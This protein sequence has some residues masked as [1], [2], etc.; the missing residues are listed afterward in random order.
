MNKNIVN[1]ESALVDNEIKV[2]V[3]L[4]VYRVERY[5]ERCI[6]SLLNQT[7]KEIEFIFVD[8]C[9]GDNSIKFVEK[10][11]DTDNRIKILYNETNLGTGRS[12]NKGIEAA[13]GKYIGFVD[14]DD[15]IDLNYYEVLYNTAEKYGCDSVKADRI[16]VFAN[17]ERVKDTI[18]K[19][20][21]DFPEY[22][23]RDDW[24]ILFNGEHQTGIYK[25]EIIKQ[26]NIRNG[27]SKVSQDTT[28]LLRMMSHVKKL[29]FCHNV[30][31][32]YY[33]IEGS[34]SNTKSDAYYEAYIIQLGEKIISINEL[35]DQNVAGQCKYVFKILRYAIFDVYKN[36][37]N[38]HIDK[39]D[40]QIQYLKGLWNETL[41]FDHIQALKVYDEIDNKVK[42]AWVRNLSDFL[43]GNFDELIGERGEYNLGFITNNNQ[44]QKGDEPKLETNKPEIS[45]KGTIPVVFLT[46]DNYAMTTAVA[47]TSLYHNKSRESGYAVYIIC[48]GVSEHNVTRLQSLAKDDMPVN[49]LFAEDEK[50]ENFEITHLHV[51][52]AAIFKFEFP[53]IFS[54]YDKILYLDGDILVLDDISELYNTDINDRYAAVVKDYKVTTYKPPHLERLHIEKKH[55]HYW[56]SG[57][58]LLN[59]KKMR[60][61][62]ITEKLFEYR[63]NGI[64]YF[65]DQDAFNVVFEENVVYLPL[66]YNML[67]GNILN[68]PADVISKYY[69]ITPY[70][71]IR[72]VISTAAV[73][74]LTG[75][76]K[77]WEHLMPFI[78]DLFIF[79][80]KK[81]PYVDYRLTLTDNDPVET[82]DITPAGA[83]IPVIY[84]CNDSIA[85]KIAVSVTSLYLNKSEKTNYDV[86]ILGINLSLKNQLR[87]EALKKDD[88]KVD[89]VNVDVYDYSNCFDQLGNAVSLL[90]QTK[91]SL[92]ELLPSLDKAIFLGADT[93][94]LKDLT[95]L[96]NIDLS[97][98]YAGVV[99]DYRTYTYDPTQAQKLNLQYG[100]YFNTGVMLLN[101]AKMREDRMSGRLLDYKK[102][103]TNFMEDSDAFNVCFENKVKFISFY[104]NCIDNVR[105]TYD[106]KSFSD[107]VGIKRFSSFAELYTRCYVI[108]FNSSKKPWNDLLP[109]SSDMYLRYYLRSTYNDWKYYTKIDKHIRKIT[110][111]ERYSVCS[112]IEDADF[113]YNKTV[114]ANLYPNS[115]YE[116]YMPDYDEKL[117][118]IISKYSDVSA[119]GLN[120]TARDRKIIVSFTT[121]PYRI[122]A[123][124]VVIS[125]LLKQTL[126]PDRI[127][128]Y[129]GE[130]EF[131]GIELPDL[132]KK[133]IECGV[134]VRYCQNILSH[135]KYYYTMQEYPDDIVITVDDDIIYDER[136][137][138]ELYK[139]YLKF[140]N[141]VSAMRVHQITFK[142]SA[143]APY[144]KWKNCDSDYI[145]VP[146]YKLIAIGC[147]GI[148]YPPHSLYEDEAFNLEDIL[149]CTPRADDLW[150]K[151]ME[152][153]NNTPVVLAKRYSTLDYIEH[154]QDVRLC[155]ENVHGNQNDVQLKSALDIYKKYANAA[156]F[157]ERL[158]SKD[159]PIPA[160][161]IDKNKLS[162]SVLNLTIE[163][164][165][166]QLNAEKNALAV[167]KK[168][169]ADEIEEADNEAKQAETLEEKLN[170]VSNELALTRKSLSFKI[171]RFI[172]WLPRKIRSLL[173]R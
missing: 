42:N 75:P 44:Y 154:T 97:D 39:T 125:I 52:T 12:R 63:E 123:A 173:K 35:G 100:E 153:M 88:F 1:S 142:S 4:P 136:L 103:G 161:Y 14:P 121:I 23:E 48:T 94:V 54:Q 140:P 80:L 34:A 106:K 165:K 82:G 101:L 132:L 157:S 99:K 66:K 110:E 69:E 138:E 5:I 139:S 61:D 32:Y 60:E 62:N 6:G 145:G 98:N 50:Y 71:S 118:E 45:V 11:A 156:S 67:C 113:F 171:G 68:C 147:G 158:L 172:T 107:K 150:L 119:D 8:D 16:K 58:M 168:K 9:G 135:K 17:G 27:I 13:K 65:M 124:A 59:L 146:S 92:P 7:L 169:L 46:D 164:M 114:T 162:V 37:L 117:D 127:I 148:L 85:R 128:L 3:V 47:I 90:T 167:E 134:E 105:E 116:I 43:N 77:P 36:L 19:R 108:L 159:D 57:M 26:Y 20:F 25:N 149:A 95:A 87:L 170:G 31:Y 70:S 112:E 141:A 22:S 15:L 160:F 38:L 41:K 86:Y 111:N 49:I 56:N 28:F 137:V 79:Y 166:H 163:K 64:N 152:T 120:Y 155:D 131:E 89:L 29:A 24:F 126:K 115:K 130:D 143:I 53:Q 30:R 144:D 55:R 76:Y 78:T 73:L 74:H 72:D 151:M 18:S 83:S 84:I 21:E 133:E 40:M 122:D 93:L 109:N 51:S 102:Y 2:S 91:F 81:S 10:A 129:L 104:F 96:Y 33:E